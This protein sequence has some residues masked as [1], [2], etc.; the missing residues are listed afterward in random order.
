MR[1][2]RYADDEVAEVNGWTIRR[3]KIGAGTS[4]YAIVLDRDGYQVARSPELPSRLDAER[5]AWAH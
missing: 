2:S 1:R 4:W 3:L 5:W